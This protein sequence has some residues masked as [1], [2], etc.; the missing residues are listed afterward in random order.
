MRRWLLAIVLVLS[1]LVLGTGL[2][3][4]SRPDAAKFGWQ[5]D[6]QAAKALARKT[7]KPLFVTFRCEA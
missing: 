5:T 3:Q 2:A 6:F 7:G 1:G 4:R